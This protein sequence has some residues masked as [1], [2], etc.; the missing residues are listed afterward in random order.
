MFGVEDRVESFCHV[1]RSENLW[2]VRGRSP[3]TRSQILRSGL[4]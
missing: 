4:A 2:P 3:Q 1:E